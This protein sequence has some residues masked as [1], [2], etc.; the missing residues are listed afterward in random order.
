MP[1]RRRSS[2]SR[3]PSPTSVPSA[4]SPP[5]PP[6]PP[7][8]PPPP[9]RHH[10]GTA[11]DCGAM[12]AEKGGVLL[13]DVRSGG[14]ADKAGIRGGDRIVEMAGMKIENLYDM[15]YALQDH[16]P[17]ETIDVVVIRSEQPVKLRATLGTR[18][19]P[20]PAFE[21]KAGKPVEKSFDG[22]KHLKDVRQ[23]T[24]GG[25]NAEAYFSP[26]GTKIIYQATVPGAGCDQQYVMDL[27]S[28]EN[29]LVSSGKGRTTCG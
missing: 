1:A 7:A 24:F 21:I 26:D 17:G 14:P 28:G 3:P 15:T 2:S 8:T 11:P 6:R 12:E 16:R 27:G 25:E 22:E 13:A 29:K 18:G 10:R 9:Q 4:P 5:P 20:P 19:A 23:L